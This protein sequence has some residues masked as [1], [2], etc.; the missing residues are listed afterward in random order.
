MKASDEIDHAL[1]G[2]LNLFLTSGDQIG[3]RR[4]AVAQPARERA[5][6]TY[7]A[8]LL[9]DQGF[10]RLFGKTAAELAK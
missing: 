1:L 8:F 4:K 9:S 6:G 5:L 7:L 10:G 2:K 3:T